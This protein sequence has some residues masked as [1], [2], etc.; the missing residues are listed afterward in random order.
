MVEYK[1]G[2]F[3]AMIDNTD[4]VFVEKFE[5]AGE[6]YNDEISKIPV[7]GKES[8]KI[9]YVIGCVDKVF[10]T[11]FG[12]DAPQKLFGE[13]QSGQL[14]VDA[15]IKL[16]NVM[17][18]DKSAHNNVQNAVNAWNGNRAQRRHNGKHKNGA[19]RK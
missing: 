5:Q 2:D 12:A 10:V 7:A 1:Y 4:A 6:V 18:S 9:R 11:L 19:H 17:R 13:S 16:V 3:S 8:E 14:R 15:F